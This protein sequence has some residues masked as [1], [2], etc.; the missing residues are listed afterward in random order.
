MNP[1]VSIIIPVYN[2]EKYLERCVDSALNQTYENLEIIL[3]NDGSTDNSLQICEKYQTENRVKIFSEENRGLP[4]ARNLG[5][6]KSSGDYIFFLDS[7]DWLDKDLI[8]KLV[9]SNSEKTLSGCNV[10]DIFKKKTSLHNRIGKPEKQE[11]IKEIISG[12]KE[13]F[14]VGYLFDA[15]VCQKIEFDE[16]TRYFEDLAYLTKYLKN[17]NETE[18]SFENESFYNYF[19]N[20]DSITLSRKNLELKIKDLFLS[21]EAI[22]K[23]TDG[24]FKTLLENRKTEITEAL[25]QDS[26]REE[27]KKISETFELPAYTGNSK[28]IKLFVNLYRGQN[29]S[30]LL[31]YYKLR[32][33]GKNLVLK[34]KMR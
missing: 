9:K 2:V 22:N 7:D 19:Q 31:R 1:K 32:K 24:Q 12:K 5:V 23:E 29:V 27:L 28:R 13:A 26:N 10:K 3:V 15:K 17:S 4:T 18:I 16:S 8:E 6:K 30:R 21:T 14:V 33:L 34:L 25:L 20:P 11:F